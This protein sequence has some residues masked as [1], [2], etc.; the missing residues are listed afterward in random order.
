MNTEDLLS[1]KYSSFFSSEKTKRE[2]KGKYEVTLR[3][4]KGEV[5]VPVEVIVIGKKTTIVSVER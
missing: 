5:K 3:N 2:D 4:A 1:F